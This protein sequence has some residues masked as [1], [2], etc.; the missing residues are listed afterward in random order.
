MED[1]EIL[2]KFGDPSSRNLAFN[3]LVRKYQTKVYWHVR[4][5]VVDHDDADDLVQ[6]VFIKVWKHLENFRQD[7]SLYTWIYRIA[8]NECLNFLQSKRR[9]FFLPINDVS[10]ELAQ[11]LEADESL[12]GD[13]VEK[14]LQQAILRLP[15][16][17]RLVFNLRYYDEMPYEQM[18]EVTGTSVGALKASYHHAAKKIEQYVNEAPD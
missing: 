2:A 4:K 8:T 7:A 12:T 6:E 18:A 11:K 9:K 3:Q 17:Q 5:M 16:K 1:Q 10:A 13:A 15:D 14:K